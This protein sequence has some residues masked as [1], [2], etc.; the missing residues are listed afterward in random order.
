M[1]L[2]GPRKVCRSKQLGSVVSSSSSSHSPG[3]AG[4]EPENQQRAG[5]EKGV[6]GTEGGLKNYKMLSKQEKEAGRENKYREVRE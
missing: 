5:L 4:R 3:T 1:V 2:A 6:A